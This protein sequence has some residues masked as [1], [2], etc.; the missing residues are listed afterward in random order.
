MARWR[1]NFFQQKE[2]NSRKAKPCIHFFKIILLYSYLSSQMCTEVITGVGGKVENRGRTR[3][4]SES[5][6]Q[7]RGPYSLI[8]RNRKIIYLDRMV[9][10]YKNSP[11]LPLC[12]PNV[13][14]SQTP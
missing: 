7:I 14:H 9:A 4:E 10:D 8:V 1:D 2:K 5:M 11:A 6:Y 12:I 3:V 13:H